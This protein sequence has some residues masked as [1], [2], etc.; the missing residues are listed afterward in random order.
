MKEEKMTKELLNEYRRVAYYYYML[1]LTQDEIAKRLKMSRQRVN[2]IVSACVKLGIVKISIEGLEQCNLELETKLEEKYG[3][4][5]VRIIDNE[6]EEEV[7]DVLGKGAAVCLKEMLND[8][9]IIGITRGRTTAAMVDNLSVSNATPKN[10]TVTQLIGS[11]KETDSTMGVS[12]LVYVLTEKLKAKDEVLYAPV[13]VGNPELKEGFM[14]DAVCKSVY[15]VMKQ[16]TIAVV[17][18]GTA[19][20]QWKHMISLY[21]KND[22][23]QSK[24]A[25]NVAGEVCTHFYDKEGNAVEPPF[26]NRIISIALQDYKNIP[27]RMGVAG[28]EEKVEAIRS[29]LIGGYINVLI[30]DS[31]TAELLLD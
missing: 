1:E 24:W 15:S 19:Q 13:I 30:T 9:D 3:L 16:C 5:E 17:G 23:N 10:L 27:I 11:T 21:D 29:A 25:E 7:F 12:R 18:I 20:S 4:R 31:K 6:D 2:R 26:R 8:N 22:V 28:G 14:Q